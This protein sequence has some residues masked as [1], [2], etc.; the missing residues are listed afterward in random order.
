MGRTVRTVG[1]TPLERH[2]HARDHDLRP[3]MRRIRMAQRRR[4]LVETKRLHEE[5]YPTH[6]DRTRTSTRCSR[7]FVLATIAVPIVIYGLSPHL[8]RLGV[9]LLS[10]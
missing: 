2:G 1:P 4:G 8:H 7:T 10:A 3:R 9:R 5:C 6:P